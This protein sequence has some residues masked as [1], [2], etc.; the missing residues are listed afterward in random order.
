MFRVLA[1]F[2]VLVGFVVVLSLFA[3]GLLVF[4]PSLTGTAGEFEQLLDEAA[5][6]GV[7]VDAARSRQQ[8]A[9]ASVRKAWS[10]FLPSFK[11]HGEFGY[12]KDNAFGRLNGQ[13]RNS[14]DNSQYG[15]SGSLP[16]YRGG[17]HY[18]GL[19]QARSNA[20]AEGYSLQETK[21]MLLLDTARAVLGIIRDRKI[22]RLQRENRA[23][24]HSILNTTKRQFDGGEATRTDIDLARDQFTAAQSVYAEALD[25]LH[26]NETEFRRLIG[27]TPGRLSAPRG[28]FGRLPKSLKQ[29]IALAE[30]QNPQLLAALQRSEA[31]QHGVKA[32]YSKFLP[33]VD[34]N[35]DYTEDRYH[36][37]GISDESDFSVKLNFSVPIFKPEAMPERDESQ[38]LAHQRSY[39]ARD[40]RYTAKAMASVAWNSYKTAVRRYGLAQQRIKAAA[41]AAKGMRREL[42]VGQRTVLDVLD[43]QERLVQAKVG[44][45]NAKFERYM[46]AHLLL[47]TT[48]Q[49]DVQGTGLVGFG[50]YLDSASR[51]IHKP[52]RSS[53]QNKWREAKTVKTQSAKRTE[54]VAKE[55]RSHKVAVLSADWDVQTSSLG[56]SYVKRASTVEHKV[57]KT[58]NV[59]KTKEPL[60]QPRTIIPVKQKV[61]Q[62]P[63]Q[64]RKSIYSKRT[65]QSD[66]EI[67]TGALP[68]GAKSY[69]RSRRRAL[70]VHK[71]PL[72][73][74]K[75][76]EQEVVQVPVPEQ[77]AVE[78]FPDT[79]Q[80]RMAVWWNSGVD[81][82]IGPAQGPRPV[83]IPVEEYRR[84]RALLMEGQ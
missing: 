9:E 84:K 45:E 41:A 42:D 43:T 31:A 71:I 49:L 81:K 79:W 11:A 4:G 29:T 19:K 12:N 20:V 22:V 8:A 74:K 36:G 6:R 51:T 68:R 59:I 28:L 46:S 66:D 76:F 2:H 25:M 60:P 70:A 32:S 14:Y 77:A 33:N 10:K 53:A 39:E 69:Q 73:I 64:L 27:R 40:A 52:L 78:E 17:A 3:S 58:K 72:P 13:G 34:L 37:A 21:Q 75:P 57:I 61:D 55:R 23:I 44:A 80:N 54:V 18:Y 65:V 50:T 38:H 7:K 48:G 35:M 24:V 26:Q 15:I 67:L 16:L 62:Q 82:V 63:Y 5:Q 30:Q 1:R 83:L 56:K 47:S